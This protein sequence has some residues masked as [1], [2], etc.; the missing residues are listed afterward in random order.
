MS[1]PPPPASLFFGS[2]Q[3]RMA[4]L[5]RWRF[6]ITEQNEL[7]RNNKAVLP[8]RAPADYFF[9]LHIQERTKNV[10]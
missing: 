3:Q 10:E 4:S 9:K 5:R 6:Y 1:I 8:K 2:E 7:K